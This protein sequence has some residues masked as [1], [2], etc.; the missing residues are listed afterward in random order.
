M[1]KLRKRYRSEKQ[2][3]RNFPDR[4]FSSWVLFH[5]MDSL[6][7]GSSSYFRSNLEQDFDR[8]SDDRK[9]GFCVKTSGDWIGVPTGPVLF[10]D[11]GSGSTLKGVGGRNVITTGFPT[12]NY[13][14]INEDS[15]TI[16]DSWWNLGSGYVVKNHSDQNA[17]TEGL[18]FKNYAT[19]IDNNSNSPFGF[20]LKTLGN[21]I[22]AP[23]A[24]RP[25]NYG[26]AGCHGTKFQNDE[27]SVFKNFGPP[28]FKSK[29]NRKVN[30]NSS[31]DIYIRVF[32]GSSSSSRSGFGKKSRAGVVKREM[33]SLLSDSIF[34][35]DVWRRVPEDGNGS[36][37]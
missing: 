17:A 3:S 8:G 16:F 25:K 23:P 35:K 21:G 5:L 27:R 37:D 30:G 1:E 20:P 13:F 2:R 22:S 33:D 10:D 9:S 26:K 12:K 24:F 29:D 19:Y 4:F 6:E 34:N 36:G 15:D 31:S 18:R 14:K 32:N 7:K 28:T 11:F